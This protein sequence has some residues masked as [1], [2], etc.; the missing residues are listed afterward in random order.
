MVGYRIYQLEH[1]AGKT[2]VLSVENRKK[3]VEI[4]TFPF[5]LYKIS[6]TS[7]HL[8]TALQNFS[9]QKSEEH[10]GSS[11]CGSEVITQLVA[12]RTQV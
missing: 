4:E 2:S 7:L 8:E 5:H 3:L 1:I 11:H 9:K 10:M 12:M 6:D